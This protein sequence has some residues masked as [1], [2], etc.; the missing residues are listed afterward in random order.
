MMVN[1]F[2]KFHRVQQKAD[3]QI[4]QEDYLGVPTW[5]GKNLHTSAKHEGFYENVRFC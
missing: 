3:H 4:D 5:L 2:V 1:L